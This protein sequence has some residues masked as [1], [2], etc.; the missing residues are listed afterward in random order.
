MAIVGSDYQFLW[1]SC[2]IPGNTRDSSIFQA[3]TLYK[4]ITEDSIIP[5]IGN[6]ENERPVYPMIVGDSAFPFRPWLLKPYTNATVD[7]DQ[8]YFNYRLSHARMV[9]EGAYGQLKVRWRL[10]MRKC[11]SKKDN[12]KIQALACLCLQNLC[13]QLKDITPRAWDLSS[14]ECRSQDEIREI[15]NMRNCRK[16]KDNSREAA[17]LRD[18]FWEEKQTL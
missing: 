3:T 13:I 2:G 5:Q 14:N 4:K 15:L 10:L 8:R 12:L 17:V 18:K 6:F 7:P 11:E 1:A 16:T 9:T